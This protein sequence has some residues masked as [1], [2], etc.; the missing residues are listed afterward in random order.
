MEIHKEISSFVDRVDSYSQHRLKNKP[1]ISILLQLSH[2]HGQGQVFDN[3]TFHAKYMYRLF[4]IM[5]R[6]SP[7]SEAYPKL[8][9][10]FKD[11]VEK[12][13]MLMRS[14]LKLGPDDI[15]QRFTDRYFAL[16]HASMENLMSISYDL[17]WIK[18]WNIDAEH[19]SDSQQH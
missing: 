4:G 18:N 14:L 9:A 6:T 12:V 16:S 7:D 15:E 3:L 10:E 17:S 11:G 19:T 8:S 5:K 2:D 1:D 13:S